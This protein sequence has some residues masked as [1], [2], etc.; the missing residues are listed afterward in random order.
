M[1][2]TLLAAD[3]PVPVTVRHE[4]GSSPFMLVADHAGNNM[5]RALGRLGLD[6]ADCE[7]HIAWD[8]GIA[9]LG[10]V[11]AGALDATLIQQDYSRLV[12][13]CNRPAERRACARSSRR[14]TSASPP[15]SSADGKPAAPQC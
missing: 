10:R 15:S 14:T 2:E 12:I 6:A 4:E 7:R 11:L 1:A 13:D 5:P 8:I 9:G 3:E